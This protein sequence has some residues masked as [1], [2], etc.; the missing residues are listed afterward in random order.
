LEPPRGNLGVFGFKLD[1]DYFWI[2]FNWIGIWK[3]IS[4]FPLH[5]VISEFKDQKIGIKMRD[6]KERERERMKEN[7]EGNL[8]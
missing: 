5:S 6:R 2:I 1:F 3:S 8:R 4:K 7:L